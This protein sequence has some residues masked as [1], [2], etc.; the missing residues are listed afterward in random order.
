M[1]DLIPGGEVKLFYGGNGN[2]ESRCI[3]H[4]RFDFGNG[5]TFWHT[6]WPHDADKDHNKAPFKQELNTLVNFLRSDI[7][8]SHDTAIRRATEMRLPML[9]GDLRYYGFHVLTPA[10][11]YYTR[12]CA[13]KGN[14]NYIY[15][16]VHNDAE[17]S[18]D[19]Y[20]GGRS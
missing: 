7:L 12:L 20:G 15:C 10:Y 17:N 9:D 18:P 4:V 16:Y 5:C 19:G 1:F 6:W 2:L 11:A 3:G 14:Y 13:Y 8:Q